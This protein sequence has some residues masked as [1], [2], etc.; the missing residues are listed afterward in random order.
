MGKFI[1]YSKEVI[2]RLDKRVTPIFLHLCIIVVA[3]SVTSN[4][5]EVKTLKEFIRVESENTMS[6]R[7]DDINEILSSTN[8]PRELL[9]TYS[10][11]K[12]TFQSTEGLTPIS[13][14]GEILDYYHQYDSYKNNNSLSMHSKII[15]LDCILTDSYMIADRESDNYE[16]LLNN[17]HY[18]YYIDINRVYQESIFVEIETFILLILFTVSTVWIIGDICLIRNLVS[19][20]E[21]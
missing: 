19:D 2:K 15:I 7:M 9:D 10:E 17:I 11:Y 21:D 18:Q 8:N 6:D 13:D 5:I 3:Y 4:I 14:V 12:N 20:D 1:N 16:E